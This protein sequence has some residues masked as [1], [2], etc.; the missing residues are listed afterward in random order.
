MGS[1]ITQPAS[2]RTPID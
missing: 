2:I 1:L